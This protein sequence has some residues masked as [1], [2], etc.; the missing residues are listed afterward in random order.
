MEMFKYNLKHVYLD[1]QPKQ[2]ETAII[3]MDGLTGDIPISPY[4]A[5]IAS[6]GY[7]VIDPYIASN[8]YY[9]GGNTFEN[10]VGGSINPNGVISEITK[11]NDMLDYYSNIVVELVKIVRKNTQAPKV[12]LLG[13]SIGSMTSRLVVDKLYSEGNNDNTI[14]GILV[15]DAY[16]DTIYSLEMTPYLKT[17]VD[18]PTFFTYESNLYHEFYDKNFQPHV[19]MNNIYS[20]NTTYVFNNINNFVKVIDNIIGLRRKNDDYYARHVD[21]GAIAFVLGQAFLDFYFPIPLNT[22]KH[23]YNDVLNDVLTIIKKIENRDTEY[24]ENYD[25]KK[26]TDFVTI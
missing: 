25:Q 6:R 26:F 3:I 8:R 16:T 5:L 14:D 12:L 24:F 7:L 23:S 10:V 11:T 20:S 18:V 1:G 2:Y 13:H 4:A 22:S 9:F 19:S 17:P 21:T 15:L